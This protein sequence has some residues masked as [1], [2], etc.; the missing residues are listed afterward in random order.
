MVPLFSNKGYGI[1]EPAALPAGLRN[2]SCVSRPADTL[3]ANLSLVAAACAALMANI[4][5]P[6]NESSGP[7]RSNWPNRIDRLVP[8]ISRGVFV[9]ILTTPVM[10]LA[11]HTADAGPRITSICL[12]SLRVDREKIPR[13]ESEEVLIDRSPIQQNQQRIRKR[14]RGGTARHVDVC[15]PTPARC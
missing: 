6:S 11:P 12:I 7:E 3:Y 9:M 14:A 13:D 8:C 5:P 10:A 2:G 4:P 15:A 1:E